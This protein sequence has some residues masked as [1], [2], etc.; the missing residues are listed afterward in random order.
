MLW[1]W[2]PCNAIK[3]I[4]SNTHDDKSVDARRRLVPIKRTPRHD[5][6]RE[7]YDVRAYVAILTFF[8]EMRCIM[9]G[10]RISDFPNFV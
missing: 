5:M 4:K 8:E 3:L 9:M 10:T 2:W 6:A 7:T 1:R